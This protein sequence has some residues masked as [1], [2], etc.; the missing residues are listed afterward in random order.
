MLQARDLA[1]GHRKERSFL[2]RSTCPPVA[3]VSR[4]SAA[5]SLGCG[6]LFSRLHA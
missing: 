4:I 2:V 6:R 3:A 5:L 1:L